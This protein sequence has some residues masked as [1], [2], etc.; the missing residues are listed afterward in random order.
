MCCRSSAHSTQQWSWDL[1]PGNG[2]WTNEPGPRPYKV[3][4]NIVWKLQGGCDVNDTEGLYRSPCQ[5]GRVHASKTSCWVT[6]LVGMTLGGLV[7]LGLALVGLTLVGL[8]Q[9]RLTLVSLSLAG[10]RIS[11]N[12]IGKL[13][14][15]L[16]ANSSRI[17]Q[18]STTSDQFNKLWQIRT[19]LR[20]SMF[21]KSR[22][23]R[24][25]LWKTSTLI[26]H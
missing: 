11:L 8:T 4:M 18:I 12:C 6:F 1:V 16:L 14:D 15:Q 3:C 19:N 26:S 13:G 24:F 9:V 17:L 21:Q 22:E 5:T 2:C 7:R 10:L 23:A 25:R 20:I